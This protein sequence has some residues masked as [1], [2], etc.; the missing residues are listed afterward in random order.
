[1]QDAPNDEPVGFNQAHGKWGASKDRYERY[2]RA[3]TVGEYKALNKRKFMNDDWKFDMARGHAWLPRLGKPA[4][5]T[6]AGATLGAQLFDGAKAHAPRAACNTPGWR[7][8]ARMQT[9][10]RAEAVHVLSGRSSGGDS[11]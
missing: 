11:L 1:V 5:Y 9:E 3:T 8:W 10:L 4:V 2:K 6:L 7:G